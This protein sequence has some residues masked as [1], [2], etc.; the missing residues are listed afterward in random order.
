MSLKWNGDGAWNDV[1]CLD[2]K[3]WFCQIQK[4]TTSTS[5]WLKSNS[6]ITQLKIK[7]GHSLF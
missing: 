5:I 3:D 6:I 2:K 7:F 4:G 1:N